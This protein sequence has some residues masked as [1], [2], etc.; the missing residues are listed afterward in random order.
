MTPEFLMAVVSK[1]STVTNRDRYLLSSDGVSFGTGL[2]VGG[3]DG[4]IYAKSGA[5]HVQRGST[6]SALGKPPPFVA[7]PTTRGQM[8]AKRQQS[9]T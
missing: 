7:S 6:R 1:L 9:T 3:C 2:V 8:S 5:E 4:F